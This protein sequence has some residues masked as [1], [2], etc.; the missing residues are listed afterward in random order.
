MEIITDF[1]N[2]PKI[3]N[4]KNQILEL[5]NSIFTEEKEDDFSKLCINNENLVFIVILDCN[6][7]VAMTSLRRMQKP[8]GTIYWFLLNFGVKPTRRRGGLGKLIFREAVKY[9]KN[10]ELLWFVKEDNYDSR[11]FYSKIGAKIIGEIPEKKFVIM[12]Y[13]NN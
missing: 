11:L 10:D 8:D 2:S 9:V 5:F 13:I 6:L 1:S 7:P 12:K 4:I 3:L